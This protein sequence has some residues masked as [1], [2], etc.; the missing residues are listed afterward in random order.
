M[1]QL[2]TLHILCSH[3]GALAPIL[4]NFGVCENGIHIWQQSLFVSYS[5]LKRTG[6]LSLS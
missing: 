2:V 4:A 1:A 6:E 3:F 5:M